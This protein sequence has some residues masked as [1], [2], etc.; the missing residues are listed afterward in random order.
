VRVY[1]PA[2]LAEAVDGE[3]VDGEAVKVIRSLLAVVLSLVAFVVVYLFAYLV[4]AAEGLRIR[5]AT[6]LLSPGYYYL[7][8]RPFVRPLPHLAAPFIWCLRPSAFLPSS[9]VR[10]P[11]VFLSWPLAMSS[12]ASILSCLLL[13]APTCSSPF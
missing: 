7:L 4:T 1:G 5:R 3:A 13:F 11:A 12:A 9:P 2:R 6:S 10:V 8:K